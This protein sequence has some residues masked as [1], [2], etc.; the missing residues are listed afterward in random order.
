MP[1]PRPGHQGTQL[2]PAPCLDRGCPQTDWLEGLRQGGL[3]GPRGRGEP[4]KVRAPSVGGFGSELGARRGQQESGARVGTGS[5]LS[6]VY[7]RMQVRGPHD[8]RH[9][10]HS[11]GSWAGGYIP[12][13][14]QG[15][16]KGTR[17]AWGQAATSSCGTSATPS[18][19]LGLFRFPARLAALPGGAGFLLICG[20]GETPCR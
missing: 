7:L 12:A 16:E 15:K 18:C 17:H 2:S 14:R 4:R 20:S 6:L 10:G 11:W 3:R 13:R 19:S 1:S 5:I 8:S 9:P